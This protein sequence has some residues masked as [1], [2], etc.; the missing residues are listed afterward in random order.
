M[1][2][3]SV[4]DAVR[5][6]ARVER[7]AIPEIAADDALVRVVASGICRSDWHLWNGD[8]GWFDQKLG[9][10]L[11]HEIGGVV[12]AVGANVRNVKTGMRVTI[13]FNL[14]CGTC[15]Y[16]R[17]GRQ[18]LCDNQQLP[19][20]LPGSGGWAEFMRAP[21]ADLNCIPLPD[22]VDELAAAALGCR[23][24]TAWRAVQ[25]RGDVRGGET[26]AIFGCGGVG[27]AAV[28]IASVLGARVIAVD[29]DD[30]KLSK[31]LQL[32]A[33]LIVNSRG[34]TGEETAQKVK[35]VTDG[36]QGADL[37]VD[38][39]G[40]RD[41]MIGAL[42]S[43]RKGGRLSQVGLTSQAEQGRIELPTDLIVINEWEIR[44]SLGN[45][46]GSYNDL[47]SMV[48]RGRLHPTKLVSE[49]VRLSDVAR[50]LDDMDNFRTDGYVIITDFN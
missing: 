2:N 19:Q 9:S 44:G 22:G 45:P 7:V 12:E 28:E 14:A 49:Q 33:D 25:A 31:M 30:R 15:P 50:V 46:H 8:W 41:T 48:A 13:P 10:T 21:N 43:L 17:K 27:Q 16:C 34:M 3:T 24:M 47:L 6:V 18:N 26:V 20:T 23:F 11:G 42:M 38:A 36:A 1:M 40:I 29:V 35:A 32:G 4:I 39:L 5:G 37:A